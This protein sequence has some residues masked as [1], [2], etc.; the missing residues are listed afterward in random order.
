ITPE[1]LH[2]IALQGFIDML[3]AGFTSVAEFHYLHHLPDGS[4]TTAMAEAVIA[5]AKETGIRLRLLPVAYFHS[6]FGM[7]PPLEGQKRF[8]HRDIDEFLRL[9]E[10]LAHAQP[11]IAPHSLRAVPPEW[12]SE[13]VSGARGVLGEDFPVHVHIAEQRREIQDCVAVHARTP[14]RL[15]ADS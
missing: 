9:L 1:Q 13:L 8:V 4:R 5:A 10:Q 3:R 12:L 11:G 7:K 15:L 6:G 2:D 14:I